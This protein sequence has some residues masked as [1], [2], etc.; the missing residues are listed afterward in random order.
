MQP[1]VQIEVL[2]KFRQEAEYLQHSC[3]YSFG[4]FAALTKLQESF[5]RWQLEYRVNQ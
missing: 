2:L 4:K 3:F 1:P 5:L